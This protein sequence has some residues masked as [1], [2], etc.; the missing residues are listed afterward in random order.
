LI[1]TS[2]A[3]AADSSDKAFDL[4]ISRGALPAQQ[5]V[6]RVDKG[7]AVRLRITSDAPGEVHFHAYRLD[8][9][10]TPGTTGEL[11]FVA[12]ATGRFRIEWHA[13]GAAAK[14]ADHHVPPLATLEVRPK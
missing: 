11:K 9:R 10:V 2:A 4:E 5:R 8:A 12:R 13:T 7:D 3:Y 1:V 6:L 14:V